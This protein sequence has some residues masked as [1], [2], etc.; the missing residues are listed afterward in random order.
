MNYQ[1][2][3][4]DSQL[5]DFKT[6][7][8]NAFCE[9]SSKTSNIQT[10]M[11]KVESMLF[12]ENELTVQNVAEMIF[13]NLFEYY[14]SDLFSNSYDVF[15]DDDMPDMTDDLYSEMYEEYTSILNK[16]YGLKIS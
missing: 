4:N 15:V 8:A 1:T 13:D 12:E 9:I 3:I 6:T 10:C 2:I 5:A 14:E 16:V 11:S 7:C